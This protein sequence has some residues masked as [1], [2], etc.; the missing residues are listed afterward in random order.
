MKTTIHAL[1]VVLAFSISSCKTDSVSTNSSV[2][3][4]TYT[5][6]IHPDTL[7]VARYTGG[8]LLSR[9]NGMAE[10]DVHFLYNFG[11]GS[12]SIE[13]IRSVPPFM[14]I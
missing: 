6:Q 13:S 8:L 5:L 9:V 10:S 3:P 14:P 4:L 2:N 7:R 12:D 1:I 11:D